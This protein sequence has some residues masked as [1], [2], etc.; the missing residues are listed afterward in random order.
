MSTV[1]DTNV[2]DIRA[3]TI[4]LKSLINTD[5][6]D[7][8]IGSFVTNGGCVIKKDLWVVGDMQIDGTVNIPGNSNATQLQGVDI[9]ATSP[10]AG[11]I[12]QYFS[13]VG[14][15]TPVNTTFTYPG[16]MVI[17]GDLTVNGTVT[18][19]NSTDL[20]IEDNLILLN[21]GE[22]GSGVSAIYSGIEID[23]GLATNYQI[24]FSD[25]SDTLE[26][27]LVGSLEPVAIRETTPVS[28]GVAFW[29][30]A[31]NR[32]ET[33]ADFTYNTG[34]DTLST[35]NLI[36][37]SDI[38]VPGTANVCSITC[39]VGNFRVTSGTNNNIIL[40]AASN[41]ITV[42]GTQATVS[43]GA[44]NSAFLGASVGGGVT[45][46]AT[47][48]YA[49]IPGGNTNTAS[50]MY[51]FAVGRSNTASMNYAYAMGYNASASH[52]GAFVMNDGTGT[53]TASTAS[54][55]LTQRFSGGTRIVSD[56]N[57]VP[58]NGVQLASGNSYWQTLAGAYTDAN[59]VEIQGRPVNSTAPTVDQAL[60][61]DGVQW[62][63]QDQTGSGGGSGS[64]VSWTPSAGSGIATIDAVYHSR[65]LE[66]AT[67]TVMISANIRFTVTGSPGTSVFING[68][69][70]AANT[71][72]NTA[73]SVLISRVSDGIKSICNLK[74][75][76]ASTALEL[77][78]VFSA[79]TQYDIACQIY[80]EKTP[81]SWTSF[82][83][84][85]GTNISSLTVNSADYLELTTT[86]ALISLDIDVLPTSAGSTIT[87]NSMPFTAD[88]GGG[89]AGNGIIIT[90][91]SDGV[92]SSA[93]VTITDASTVATFTAPF[94]ATSYNIICQFFY[95]KA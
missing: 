92:L 8:D 84:T 23:R 31:N 58:V 18:N 73:N 61:W 90:R 43:G 28:N 46:N 91:I 65:Y 83:P 81:G 77:E 17:S 89:V 53:A 52:V 88:L 4:S 21:K 15:W 7:D 32:F 37:G 19:V 72:F 12:L 74:V 47:G 70:Y 36:L 41:S 49:T 66:P 94:L 86:T 10:G 11:A 76:S 85:A 29:N 69:P 60:V 78:S 22:L 95:E 42:G 40:G 6:T 20:E 9:S 3:S 33:D 44:S 13:G 79:S 63:P 51:S 1:W 57:V 45:N 59:A 56:T 93:Q 2:K 50:G 87:L 75:N 26:I 30:T 67:N 35:T 68:L 5:F 62:I 71:G 64:F 54:N 48:N 16:D 34:T 80:Y 25:V 14:E 82:T 38:T 27:G 55:Q 24:V 39:A